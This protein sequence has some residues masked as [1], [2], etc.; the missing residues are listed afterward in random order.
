M[1]VLQLAWSLGMFNVIPGAGK[2]V[3]FSVFIFI[4]FFFFVQPFKRASR[5]WLIHIM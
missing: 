4:F 2:L 5:R 3:E 1:D